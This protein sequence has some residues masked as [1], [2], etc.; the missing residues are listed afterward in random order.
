M[1]QERALMG[2]D[3]RITLT[4]FTV[5]APAGALAF[6]LLAV[7]LIR[8]RER[9]AWVERLEHWLVAPLAVCMIGLVASATH[10]GTP[11]NALYVFNGWGRS[12]LSNEVTSAL[13]FLVIA[14]AYWLASFNGKLPLLLNRLWLGCSCL[15]ALWL[16]ARISVVYA[17]LTIPTWNSALVPPGLWA[18]SLASA[19]L[20]TLATLAFAR[21]LGVELPLEATP[22][23]RYLRAL[24]C[25]A[26]LALIVAVIFFCVQNGE[27][28]RIQN[29]FGTASELVPWYNAAI[30][31][32]GILGAL[33][34]VVVALPILRTGA[35]GV[36]SSTAGTILM[37]SGAAL[38]RVAFY[39]MHMTL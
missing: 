17:I 29:A 25:C 34:I 35:P 10:L 7:L 18:L 16:V 28:A 3:I 23:R 12:P 11:S 39:S 1:G 8:Q 22:Q 5:L 14:G 38:I 15:A 33:G 30:A 27:L 19:P 21:R 13:G 24:L 32:F 31:A 26:T 6:A 37:L 4:A 9:A 36:L 2:I 20:V